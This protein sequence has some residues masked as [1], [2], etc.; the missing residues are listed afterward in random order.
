MRLFILI[1]IF[2]QRILHLFIGRAL[3]LYRN[4]FHLCDQKSQKAQ[5]KRCIIVSHGTASIQSVSKVYRNH[6]KLSE[7][8]LISKRIHAMLKRK[9][10]ERSAAAMGP[11]DL[12]DA[13]DEIVYVS[14]PNTYELLYAQPPLPFSAPHPGLQGQAMLCTAAGASPPLVL[15]APMPGSHRTNFTFGNS[16]TLPWGG[17][18][19]E[20]QTD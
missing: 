6:F 1:H 11:Q 13:L 12:L 5:G 3:I 17:F 16:I 10:L 18:S 19:F 4:D 9:V 20:R 2:F 15:T 7:C 8:I 14:D